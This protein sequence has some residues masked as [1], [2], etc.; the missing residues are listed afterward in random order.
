LSIN[1]LHI[2]RSNLSHQSKP[3]GEVKSLQSF[4]MVTASGSRVKNRE[5]P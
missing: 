5:I 2:D 4:Q 3:L 1:L